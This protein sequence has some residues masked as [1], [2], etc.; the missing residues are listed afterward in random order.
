[1]YNPFAEIRQSVTPRYLGVDIGT[2]SIKIVEIEEGSQLPRVINYAL[3]ESQA[4]LTRA[5][6]VFQTST[7]KLFDE[8]IA[9]LLKVTLKKMRPKATDVV[10]SLP[11]FSAFITVLNFPQMSNDE[12]TNAMAFQAR[13]YIPLPL[14]EV[15]LDWQKIG[16]YTD[17]QG[18]KFQ[19]VLL[20]SVPQEQIRKYQKMFKE[21][22]LRLRVLEVEGLGLARSL[23]GTDPTP[24]FI[25]DIG[26][27]STVIAIVD[28]GQLK[29]SAQTDFAGGSLTQ[30]LAESLGINPL[31]AEE[32]KRERGI[33]GT[34]PNYELSTIMIPFLDAIM[35]EVRRVYFNYSTQ[36]PSA[37]KIE[38][39]ILSGGSANLLG[40]E[41]YWSDQFGLPT[42]K[43]NP[44]S[45]FE[46]PRDLEAIIGDLNPLMSV[47]LGLTLRQ[48]P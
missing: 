44:F 25:V 1:M 3:V 31:R 40:I 23:I 24:S 14:S 38:R 48:F 7:L 35:N 36:F 34:G 16:E 21:V 13:Q 37:P 47:A 46:Y 27:R 11:G 5:N 26:S 15:A 39:V 12:L 10:A 43:A 42:V 45:Q 2:T 22:G 6:T 32:L 33:L 28:Q 30:A 20:I 17:D 18:F 4:S 41:K 19:Q 29:F 8:Q 9:E